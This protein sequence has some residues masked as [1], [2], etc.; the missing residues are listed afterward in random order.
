MAVLKYHD[1][2]GWEPVVSALQGPTGPTGVAVG[3]PTGG[4][5][6]AVLTK[7]STTDYATEWGIPGKILQVVQTVKTDTFTT[8]SNSYVNVT[9]LSATITPQSN[10]NKI[11]IFGQISHGLGNNNGYGAFKITRG[12]TD[13]YLGDAAGDRVRGVFG[14]DSGGETV[15]QQERRKLISESIIFLDSPNTSSSITYNLKVRQTRDTGSPVNINMAELDT[16]NIQR[17]RGASSITLME[18]A[19]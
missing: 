8:S 1:G 11:L 18:V 2:A 15:A 6:G 16:D 10:T 3:L 19:I 13:I 5:T 4:A 9:G 12:D 14:G 17:V 7:T